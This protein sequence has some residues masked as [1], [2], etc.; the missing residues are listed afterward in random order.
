MTINNKRITLRGVQ[1]LTPG[2]ILW[3]ADVKGFGVRCQR[4]DKV[5]ILKTRIGGRTYWFSIG[6]HG[7]PWT[8]E[9]ARREARCILGKIADGNNPAAAREARRNRPT[10]AELCDRFLDEYAQEHKKPLSVEGDRRNIRN[11]INPILG[12]VA[13]PT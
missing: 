9:T 5:Y 12:S 1:T 3:D 10:I 7:S 13:W 6:K 2:G 11:H 4:R 8:P